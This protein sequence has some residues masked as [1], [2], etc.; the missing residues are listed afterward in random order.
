M[1]GTVYGVYEVKT[2]YLLQ[3]L[4]G[5]VRD[6]LEFVQVLLVAVQGGQELSG[7]LAQVPHYQ[8]HAGR[9]GQVQRGQ[10]DIWTIARD[11]ERTASARQTRSWWN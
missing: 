7:R 5:E 10:V 6:I 4:S 8:P 11:T 1:F 2:A 3:F 9:L